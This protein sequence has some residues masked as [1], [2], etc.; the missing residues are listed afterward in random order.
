MLFW[1][2]VQEENPYVM[3]HCI[4]PGVFPV[5]SSLMLNIEHILFFAHIAAHSRGEFT[6]AVKLFLSSVPSARGLNILA[7]T[8]MIV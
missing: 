8:P 2:G 3:L 7:H 5:D 6:A 4:R 1:S